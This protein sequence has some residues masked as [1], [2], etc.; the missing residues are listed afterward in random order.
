MQEAQVVS[1]GGGD[2][3]VVMNIVDAG[4]SCGG[5]GGD[6]R[7]GGAGCRGRRNQG[8]GGGGAV[9]SR[10]RWGCMKPSTSTY[11]RGRRSCLGCAQGAQGRWNCGKTSG[12][13]SLW[14]LLDSGKTTLL[15]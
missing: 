13:N 7:S 15:V 3:V 8:G 4:V 14:R 6:G 10:G 1:V 12:V 5:S 2:V 11:C 9:V